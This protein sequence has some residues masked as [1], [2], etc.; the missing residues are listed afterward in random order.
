MLSRIPVFIAVV[1]NRAHRL[2]IKVGLGTFHS[3]GLKTVPSRR[4]RRER[5]Q[6]RHVAVAVKFGPFDSVIIVVIPT[7]PLPLELP[8]DKQHEG[9]C[10]YSTHHRNGH[11]GSG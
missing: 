2:A 9:E 8:D 10:C 6:R 1:V 4:P 5:V 7:K 11:D 3:I